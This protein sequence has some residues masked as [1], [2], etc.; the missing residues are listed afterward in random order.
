MPG[1]ILTSRVS[2]RPSSRARSIVVWP[3]ADGGEERDGEVGLDVGRPRPG[4]APARP[5]AAAATRPSR[6]SKMP[7]PRPLALLGARRPKNW[8]KSKFSKPPGPRLPGRPLRRARPGPGG[9]H[10]LERGVAVA[11]VE[12][13]LLGVAQDVV[14]LLRLLELGLGLLVARVD[15]GVM[16][17]RQV[18]VG[19]LDLRR[20]R[21]RG[22]R[23]GPRN[24]RVRAWTSANPSASRD[25]PAR[26]AAAPSPLR[27]T[28]YNRRTNP[29]TS[30]GPRMP[31]RFASRTDLAGGR[32]SC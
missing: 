21:R 23:P 13:P 29:S 4:P 25:A 10:P 19:L 5:P 8:L 18:A 28:S 12:R 7:P 22:A 31:P 26:R 14:G 20:P 30:E 9:A 24:N 17:P 1:G 6:S 32:R 11:V 16:L 27:P 3:A 2:R 15:V